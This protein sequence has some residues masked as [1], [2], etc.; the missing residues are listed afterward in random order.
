MIMETIRFTFKEIEESVQRESALIARN[1]K[2]NKGVDLTQELFVTANDLAMLRHI[3]LNSVSMLADAA[4]DF[5]SVTEE[6]TAVNFFVDK[7]GAEWIAKLRTSILESIVSSMMAEWCL[8]TI[9]DMAKKYEL[10]MKDAV[11]AFLKQLYT[12]RKPY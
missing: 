10:R 1:R 6:A 12:K 4:K 8:D 7:D 2:D 5:A 9:P 11:T 3:L